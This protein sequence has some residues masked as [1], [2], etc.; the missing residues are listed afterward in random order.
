MLNSATRNVDMDYNYLK[1]VFPDFQTGPEQNIVRYKNILYHD[2]FPFQVCDV[3]WSNENCILL[4]SIQVRQPIQ[5]WFPVK[6]FMD[7][8][9][10]FSLKNLI[11]WFL[12]DTPI[13]E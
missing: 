8:E 7:A 11:D 1:P 12:R 13:C 4:V 5:I 10:A 6:C 9:L 3:V 2:I